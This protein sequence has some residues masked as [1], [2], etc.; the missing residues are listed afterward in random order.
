[1]RHLNT[2]ISVIGGMLVAILVSVTCLAV[3]MRY[4]MNQPIGWTEEISAL[5]M[6][7]IVML[8]AVTCEWQKRHLTIDLLVDALPRGAQKLLSIVVG[9]V[10][11]A[12]LSGIAWLAWRLAQTTGFKRTQI[13]RLSWFWIDLAVVVG[14]ALAAV[15]VLWRLLG[16]VPDDIETDTQH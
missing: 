15:V 6:I 7:W 4:V 9:L 5:L 8:G 13:L 3:F 10:S 16:R 11:I 1:M 14:A 2:L 12:T